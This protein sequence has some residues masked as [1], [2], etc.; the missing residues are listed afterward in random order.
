M[1]SYTILMIAGEASGDRIASRAVS[2]FTYICAGKRRP[3]ASVIHTMH[4]KTT[5]KPGLPRERVR[6]EKPRSKNGLRAAPTLWQKIDK[7]IESVPDAEW[8][9]LPKDGS[10]NVDHYLY[11]TPKQ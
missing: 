8:E 4:T 11:G 5:S 10:V 6:P 7:L 9:K 3:F 1:T 2:H